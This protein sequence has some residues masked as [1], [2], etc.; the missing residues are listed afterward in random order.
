MVARSRGVKFRP[1]AR[2]PGLLEP[3]YEGSQV[4]ATALLDVAQWLG[5]RHN[6]SRGY[7][8]ALEVEK[9]AIFKRA[10]KPKKKKR[11]A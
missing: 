1:L 3:L 10:R 2:E 8:N 7:L 5:F 11:S 4:A 6:N 9:R